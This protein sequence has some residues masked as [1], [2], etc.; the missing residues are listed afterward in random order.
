MQ[1]REMIGRDT[2]PLANRVTNLY[3]ARAISTWDRTKPDY[4]FWDKFRRGKAV[5][6]ELS[7]TLAKP[8]IQTLIS[9]IVGERLTIRLAKPSGE[10]DARAYTNRQLAKFLERNLSGLVS[11]LDDLYSMGDQYVI[12][13]AD[14]TLSIPSPDTVDVVYDLLDYR[15]MVSVTI[16]SEFDAATV[17]DTYTADLRTLRIKWKQAVTLDDGTARPIG[18]E[19]VSIF[20]NLLGVI[21]V[22]H[23]AQGR[24][25][26]ETNGRPIYEALLHVFSRYN[27][28]LE[29]ALDGA[30]LLS[31]PI[32]AFEGLADIDETYNA[33]AI[34]DPNGELDSSGKVRKILD[35]SRIPALFL[36]AGG[37]FRFASPSTGFTSDIREM[38]N[39]L[40]WLVI[41]HSRISEGA[42][43]TELSSARATAQEQ[44]KVLMMFIRFLRLALEGVGRDDEENLPAESGLLQLADLWLMTKRLTNPRIVVEQ[45]VIE[46]EELNQQDEA[47]TFE[48]VKYA[49]AAG[50]LSNQTTLELL[51][52]VDDA[53][54]ELEKARAE[55]EANSIQMALDD[56]LGDEQ[57][58]TNDNELPDQ[59]ALPDQQADEVG[60]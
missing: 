55:A 25:G 14:G 30:E 12:V 34:D 57:A 49:D 1:I 51:N 2:L 53:S 46:W 47:L 20:P 29:K 40:F 7:G 23:F 24:S 45:V 38:L 35:F 27:D 32:P 43:G 11:M 5:G 8:I 58:T 48:K 44:S 18:S 17:M 60:A 42:W 39:V 56:M 50:Y 16:T 22:V 41:E 59:S 6:Y 13:N 9:Y 54:A 31:N 36:G 28:S 21:P 52:L 33:N 19:N 4:A 26:N 3:R 10:E 15:R 37:S